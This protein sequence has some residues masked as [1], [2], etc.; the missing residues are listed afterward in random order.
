MNTNPDF[1]NNTVG[2]SLK[3]LSDLPVKELKKLSIEM[4]SAKG[5]RTSWIQTT[6][7]DVLIQYLTTG[8]IPMSGRFPA[9]GQFWANGH[10]APSVPDLASIIAAAIQPML[11]AP[12][13]DENSVVSLIDARLNA[14]KADFRPLSREIKV[15]VPD[16]TITSV[17]IQH[18]QF[19]ELLAYVSQRENVY[20]VGPAASGKTQVAENVALALGLEFSSIS[21]CA[22]TP[23][24]A[25]FGFMNAM[26][27]YVTSEFRKRYELGGIFLCDEF[28]NGNANTCAALNQAT[29]NGVCAFPDGMIKRHPDFVCIAAGNTYGTGADRQY[30]GRNQLD[31]ATLDRFVFLDWDYDEDLELEI[32]PDRT[33]TQYVQSVRKAVRTLK[34]R[35]IVSM[36]ASIKGGKMLAAGQPLS[37]IKQTILWK[38]LSLEEIS[39]IEA[40]I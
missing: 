29:S 10:D 34:V 36:R 30:V 20:L 2:Y 40:A 6:S 13:L 16:G 23:V 1:N 9:D 17:G 33:W 38:G 14:F 27:L 35:H 25:L 11:S 3:F 12:K 39:K 19:E 26:G 28:D 8:E 21:V 37:R 5:H 4:A 15:T 24:S 31:G 7:K 22:Q 18:K 32:S